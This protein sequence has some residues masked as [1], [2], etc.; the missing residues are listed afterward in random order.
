[1]VLCRAAQGDLTSRGDEEENK[2]CRECA[3]PCRDRGDVSMTFPLA[4]ATSRPGIWSPNI[5]RDTRQ[6]MKLLWRSWC[7]LTWCRP[8]LRGRIHIYMRFPKDPFPE[9]D[10]Q[11][12]HRCYLSPFTYTCSMCIPQRCRRGGFEGRRVGGFENTPHRDSV[13]NHGASSAQHNRMCLEQFM[14]M[15]PS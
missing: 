13:K 8:V 12:D 7:A 4:G 11:T 9:T 15:A 1:M 6:A 2:T 14:R 10:S 5:N 3:V